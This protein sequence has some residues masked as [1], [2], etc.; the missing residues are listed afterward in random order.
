MTNVCQF[1][2]VLIS[3]ASRDCLLY[4]ETNK[5]MYN[6]RT[7]SSPHGT[8]NNGYQH[9]DKRRQIH[10]NFTFGVEERINSYLVQ[11]YVKTQKKNFILNMIN[12]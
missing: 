1:K 10:T 8:K 11:I 4:F 7:G 3:E 2:T 5:C 6:D 12:F 9:R